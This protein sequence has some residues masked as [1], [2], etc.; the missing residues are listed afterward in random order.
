MQRAGVGAGVVPPVSAGVV[1]VGVVRSGNSMCQLEEAVLEVLV[2]AVGEGECPGVA[3]ISRRAGATP[4]GV[5]AGVVSPVSAGVVCVGKSM[6]QLEEAVL[7]VLV[8]AVG[9]ECPGVAGVSGRAGGDME[10]ERRYQQG[11]ARQRGALDRLGDRPEIVLCRGR[12][13]MREIAGAER[14][15]ADGAGGRSD[16]GRR[17]GRLGLARG[18]FGRVCRARSKPAIPM[19]RCS[20]TPD[21]ESC[22]RRSRDLLVGHQLQIARVIRLKPPFAALIAVVDH[23]L[24]CASV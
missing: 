10:R 13:K 4:A 23:C 14:V 6:G 8:E 17:G 22:W 1:R 19:D 16:A 21:H 18:G 9:G 2:E 12:S 3:E 7:D 24:L 5:G 15:R 20:D 11:R